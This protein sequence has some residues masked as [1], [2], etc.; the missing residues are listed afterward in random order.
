ME[1]TGEKEQGS[2]EKHMGGVIWKEKSARWVTTG[3]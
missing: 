2:P 3:M 1:S